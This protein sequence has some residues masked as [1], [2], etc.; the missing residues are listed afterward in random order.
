MDPHL[1][2]RRVFVARSVDLGVTRPQDVA[3]REEGERRE[4][5]VKRVDG[6]REEEGR[7]RAGKARKD[8][9]G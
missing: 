9:Y 6:G 2:L 5:E 1:L 4:G 3:E 7:E 8:R